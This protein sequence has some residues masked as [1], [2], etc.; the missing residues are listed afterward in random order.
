M[1]GKTGTARFEYW[2]EGGKYQASFAGFYPAD[3]P[4]YTCM[5][6]VNQPQGNYYGGVVAAP[7]FKEIA[8][9]TFLKTPLNMREDM[10]KDQK[11]D[12]KKM[13][14]SN[15]KIKIS[16]GQMP[17]LVGLIGKN[18]IP[19]LENLGYGVEY[20]GVGKILEQFPEAGTVMKKDQKI[21]LRMQN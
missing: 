16:G 19:Q 13:T 20:K 8:G 5:V 1:A 6:M 10:L 12:L 4:K 21:Y 3:N 11:V 9:K 7:V 17:E 18:I 14:V 15:P 2:K